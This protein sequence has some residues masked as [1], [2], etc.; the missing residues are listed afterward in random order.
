MILSN[1][2]DLG[3]EYDTGWINHEALNIDEYGTVYVITADNKPRDVVEMIHDALHRSTSD[4][5]YHTAHDLVDDVKMWFTHPEQEGT[6]LDN[7]FW[8]QVE[9]LLSLDKVR[10]EIEALEWAKEINA[11]R[12]NPF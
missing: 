3:L 7:E 12:K 11:M 2:G 1:Y 9:S 8:N 6:V 10:A 4:I 5:A